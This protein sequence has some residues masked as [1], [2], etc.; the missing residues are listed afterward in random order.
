L[1]E[2]IVEHAFVGDAL[3]A[4]WRR[5]VF[6]VE[7]MRSELDA[8]GYDVVMGR[9]KIVRHIQF[10]AGIRDKP[11][12][13]S[14]SSA[15]A[16]KPSGCVIWI[17]VDNGLNM[18]RFWWFGAGP[19][20]PLPPL[21]DRISKRIRRTKEGVRPLRKKHRIVNG[22]KFRP[23]GTLDEVLETLFGVLPSGTPPILTDDDEDK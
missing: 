21:G 8:H 20:E 22:S 18:K 1:R 6:D 13:V 14:V 19:K 23:I 9:D 16:D 15:L 5:G 17:Q 4:L 11:Q 7:V 3:R 12:G 10:K 2:K